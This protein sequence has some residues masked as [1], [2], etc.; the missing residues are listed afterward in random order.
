M[1]ERYR[2][3]EVVSDTD[4][5]N[6]ILPRTRSDWNELLGIIGVVFGAILVVAGLLYLRHRTQLT[7]EQ[8]WSS[9]VATIEDT[10][11]TLVS[12]VDSKYGGS[13]LYE[14]QVFAAFSVNG[15]QQERWITVEQPPKT[16]PSA[17]FEQAH[18]KGTHCIVRWNP[19]D[20][21]EIVV[22]LH[23]YPELR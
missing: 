22:E 12:K 5:L 11:T 9:A 16:L 19:S 3:H 2:P 13:M 7:R 8:G 23:R 1:K 4:G 17:Q 10:R 15:S 14:V 18:W 20:P 6:T 21:K